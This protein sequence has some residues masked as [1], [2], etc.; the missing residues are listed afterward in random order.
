[1]WRNTARSTVVERSTTRYYVKKQKS[2][3]SLEDKPNENN[4]KL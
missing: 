1:M 2:K 4:G 3:S